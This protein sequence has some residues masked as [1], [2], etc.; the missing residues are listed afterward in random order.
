MRVIYIQ[1]YKNFIPIEFVEK[2]NIKIKKKIGVYILI[3]LLM[4]III[5]VETSKEINIRDKN[6]GILANV[7]RED[8]KHIGNELIEKTFLL[9]DILHSPGVIRIDIDKN[10]FE[11]HVTNEYLNSIIE[12]IQGAKGLINEINYDENNFINIIRGNF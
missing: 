9:K 1:R 10:N 2:Y 12:K 8:I 11:I 7:E 5:Y 6:N 3:T 4:N